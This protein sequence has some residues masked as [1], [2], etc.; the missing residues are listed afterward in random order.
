MNYSDAKQLQNL[1]RSWTVRKLENANVSKRRIRRSGNFYKFVCE[2]C[3]LL[4]NRAPERNPFWN[5]GLGLSSLSHMDSFQPSQIKRN[6]FIYQ[7]FRFHHFYHHFM[8][9]KF[10]NFNFFKNLNSIP[11]LEHSFE[12][13][14]QLNLFFLIP[15]PINTWLPV[16]SCSVFCFPS[17]F[18]TKAR[19]IIFF[20]FL[21]HPNGNSFILLPISSFWPILL[22]SMQNLV[23]NSSPQ[24]QQQ[25]PPS[26]TSKN[27]HIKKA[28]F[29][30]ITFCFGPRATNFLS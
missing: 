12:V 25:L 8:C 24:Q 18:L 7:L 9:L 4:R 11:R 17:N 28:C 27:H 3:F 21:K 19:C 26:I 16:E 23:S 10:W 30:M 14:P 6:P 2:K 15:P 13:N 20:L 1:K 5:H 22:F 29:Q